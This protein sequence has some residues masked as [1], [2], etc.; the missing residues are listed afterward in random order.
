MLAA[1]LIIGVIAPQALK[2]ESSS[3]QGGIEDD[4]WAKYKIVLEARDPETGE[5]VKASGVVKVI[6]KVIDE[7]VYYYL[8]DVSVEDF[9]TN[10][11]VSEYEVEDFFSSIIDEVI[12][13]VDPSYLPSNGVLEEPAFSGNAHKEYDTRTGLLRSAHVSNFESFEGTISIGLI[14]TSVEGVAPAPPADGFGL[15]PLLLAGIAGAAIVVVVVVIILMKKR[16]KQ[17]QVG[18]VAPGYAPPQAP[19]PPPPQ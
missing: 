18:Y 16:S 10:T 2:L 17:A 15:S 13:Y 7:Y 8:D 3:N 6:F 14:D 12:P 5:Y 4:D 1:L 11:D 9:D 19:P